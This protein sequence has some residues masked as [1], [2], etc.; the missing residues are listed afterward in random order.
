MRFYK[1]QHPFYCG[2]DLHA[3]TMYLCV[4]NNEGEV[5]LHRNIRSE[6]EKFLKAIKPYKKGLVVACECMFAW[7]WLADCCQDNGIDFVLGHALYMKAIHGGK[8]KNDRIDAA[9]IAGLLRGG[10]LPQSYVYPRQ[11]RAT[12]DLMRRRTRLVRARSNVLAHIQNTTFQY[13][14]PSFDKKLTYKSNRQG[15]SDRFPIP[16]VKMSIDINLNLI[17]A[18]DEQI[19]VMEQFIEKNVK[20]DN[21]QDYY[22]LRSV[23]GIGRILALTILYEIH[24]IRRFK[25]VGNFISYSR[26]VK[27]GHESG[28][29]TKTNKGSGKMGNAHLK[30]AFSEATCLFM[31]GN[32]RAKAIV[33]RKSAKC[34]KG[35]AMSIL[36]AKLGRAIYYMLKCKEPFDENRFF[37]S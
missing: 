20:I 34:G 29:K 27:C 4:M 35:K 3:R 32:Q 25:D 37:E 28:G 18:Y 16:S 13:N 14:L 12:R 31:R 26:L 9:K 15:A 6:P 24:D 1:S 2:V 7:Y 17:E 8:V 10:L 22:L 11:M 5:L 19:R 23:S 21:Q 36:S 30:W 33:E